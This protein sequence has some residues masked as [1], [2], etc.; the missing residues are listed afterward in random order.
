MKSKK[1]KK[2]KI[3]LYLPCGSEPAL[4]ENI[5]KILKL[6]LKTKN[7]KIKSQRL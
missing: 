1:I 4:T 5:L 3:K 2:M 7:K 6:E